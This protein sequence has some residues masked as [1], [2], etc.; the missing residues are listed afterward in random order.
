MKNKI[1][2]ILVDDEPLCI[3][4]LEIDLRAVC[5]EIEIIETSTS[6][7]KA[8]SLIKNSKSQLNLKK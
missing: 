7:K 2:A 8:I 5:P 4:G 3:A 6:S 1:R